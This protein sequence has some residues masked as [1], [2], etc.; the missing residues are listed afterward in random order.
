MRSK[1]RTETPVLDISVSN[2]S[3]SISR[4]Y[5]GVMTIPTTQSKNL[6]ALLDA[7]LNPGKYNLHIHDLRTK[8]VWSRMSYG[9]EAKE[10]I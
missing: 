4:N 9:K 5:E 1:M 10:V 6:I 2:D 8:E 7:V 3:V